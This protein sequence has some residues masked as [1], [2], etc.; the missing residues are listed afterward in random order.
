LVEWDAEIP[1][2][3]ILAAEAAQADIILGRN[4]SDLITGT[5]VNEN[6]NGQ[7]ANVH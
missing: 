5:I 2:W 7:M 4:R 6:N 1:D 3:P